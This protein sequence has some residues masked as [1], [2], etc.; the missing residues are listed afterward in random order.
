MYDYILNTT[1]PV[2]RKHIINMYHNLY[3]LKLV[4]DEKIYL[5]YIYYY[6]LDDSDNICNQLHIL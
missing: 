3:L 4:V 1:H 2:S 5:L 6:I